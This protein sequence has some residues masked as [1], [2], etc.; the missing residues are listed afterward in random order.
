TSPKNPSGILATS[1]GVFVTLRTN[2]GA[3]RGCIGTIEPS[4]SQVAEEII[5]SA[6]KAATEDPRFPR[7]SVDELADLTY[8]VDILSAAET[9]RGPVDLDPAV[10]GVI[11]E[12]LDS[13]RRGLLLPG[14]EGLETVDKQ[15]SAVHFK[16]GINPGTPVRVMRFTVTRF[17]KE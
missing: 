12:S 14:I 16:A 3:L 17:G 2:S 7:V 6:I 15:W 5:R 8:G 4:R 10:Y 13:R 1:A 11:I 9:I